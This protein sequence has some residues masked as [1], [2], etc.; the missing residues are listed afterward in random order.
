MGSITGNPRL[1]QLIGPLLQQS[2]LANTPQ[3]QAA[4][5]TTGYMQSTEQAV[6]G[7]VNPGQVG[8]YSVDP[9]A[10]ASRAQDYTNQGNAL[11]AQMWGNVGNNATSLLSSLLNNA[12]QQQGQGLNY[13]V[14][15]G[16][17]NLQRAN[18]GWTDIYGNQSTPTGSSAGAGAS[19]GNP[20]VDTYVNAVRN[21]YMTLGDV[22]ADIKPRVMQA[23][24][25]QGYDVAKEVMGDLATLEGSYNQGQGLGTGGNLIAKGE[26]GLSDLLNVIGFRTPLETQKQNYSAQAKNFTQKYAGI[27]GKDVALPSTSDTSSQ[28][29]DKFTKLLQTIQNKYYNGGTGPRP[30]LDTF[31]K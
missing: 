25:S 13:D 15:M 1:D 2:G 22:P 16:N 9:T 29:K 21:S 14:N 23:L 31:N 18:S 4:R 30:S 17:L 27:L 24:Q 11:T 10:L 26:Q 12:T 19:T 28:A 20:R 8:G 5:D 3:A 7:M 6:N